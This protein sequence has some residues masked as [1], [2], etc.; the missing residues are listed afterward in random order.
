MIT[1]FFSFLLFVHYKKYGLFLSCFTLLD[2]KGSNLIQFLGLNYLVI[3][4]FYLG[5]N[6][7]FL[8]KICG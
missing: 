2:I 7:L 8:H 4:N 5:Q 1:F 3:F 6:L